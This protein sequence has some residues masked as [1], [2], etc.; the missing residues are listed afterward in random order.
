VAAEVD[1]CF[2]GWDEQEVG[3]GLRAAGVEELVE[4]GEAQL[5]EIARVTV[6]VEVQRNRKSFLRRPCSL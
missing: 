4:F 3:S 6:A 5:G 2:L 1:V